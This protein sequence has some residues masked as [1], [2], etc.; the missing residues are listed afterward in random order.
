[1]KLHYFEDNDGNFGDAIN[2]WFWSRVLPGLLGENDG[3]RLLGIGTIINN[4]LPREYQYWVFGSGAGYGELPADCQRWRV[5]CVRG[6]LTAR[7]LKL[8]ADLAVT[9]PAALC[10]RLYQVSPN[11]ERFAASFIPHYMSDKQGDW[12]AI[13]EAANI[14][15]ISPTDPPLSVIDQIVRSD[16]VITEAMHGAILADAYRVPWQACSLYG[17]LNPKWDDWMLSMG[18]SNPPLLKLQQVWRGDRGRPIVERLKNRVKRSLIPFVPETVQWTPPPNRQSSEEHC[19]QQVE[20]LRNSVAGEFVL[21]PQS[22]LQ[23]KLDRL[24][25]L[26]NE[27]RKDIQNSRMLEACTR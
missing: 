24:E 3:I 21:S 1:M 26:L 5:Y 13:C 14:H 17:I 2:P 16:R 9:D 12:K 6:P 23:Q 19:L 7:Q 10:A 11:G 27:L 18:L 4:K 15:Y 25:E 20:K 8:D 22:I